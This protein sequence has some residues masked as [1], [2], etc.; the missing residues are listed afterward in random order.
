MFWGHSL[1]PSLLYIT[2]YVT[3][4]LSRFGMRKCRR[5]RQKV[6]IFG[7]QIQWLMSLSHWQGGR[8]ERP[9]FAEDCGGAAAPEELRRIV[10]L[11]RLTVCRDVT[12]PLAARIIMT[13]SLC[14]VCA[15][16]LFPYGTQPPELAIRWVGQS[17]KWMNNFALRRK[18]ETTNW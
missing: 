1:P 8:V 10:S 6:R 15:V 7:R 16:W 18:L 5:T 11:Q 13:T 9:I 4:W 12:L 3:V 2:A 14:Q 17:V